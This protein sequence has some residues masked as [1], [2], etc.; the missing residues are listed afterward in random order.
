MCI[1]DRA[2]AQSDMD[3]TRLE[4]QAAD[5]LEQDTLDAQLAERKRKLGIS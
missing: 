1:R 5:V 3:A 4:R 2:T